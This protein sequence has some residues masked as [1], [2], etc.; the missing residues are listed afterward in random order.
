VGKRE[1]RKKEIG[2]VREE[3]E[4]HFGKLQGEMGE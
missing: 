2:N 1:G 3:E 4:A